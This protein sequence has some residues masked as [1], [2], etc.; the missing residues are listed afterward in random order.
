M[1]GVSPGCAQALLLPLCSGI[2]PGLTRGRA[3]AFTTVLF[4]GPLLLAL[5]KEQSPQFI[6]F[7]GHTQQ[8]S[9]LTPGPA[10]VITPGRLSGLFGIPEIKSGWAARKAG[11]LR[12]FLR[13][14]ISPAPQ[15]EFS[16][17]PRLN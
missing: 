11:T 16:T 13:C 1:L 8:F 3:C 6:W 14:T 9:G 5:K 7:W 2:P 4:L 12:L 15:T 17:L 10:Q